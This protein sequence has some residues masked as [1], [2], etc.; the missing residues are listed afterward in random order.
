MG[1]TFPKNNATLPSGSHRILVPVTLVSYGLRKIVT[2][3]NLKHAATDPESEA[4]GRNYRLVIPWSA[5]SLTD[6]L[7]HETRR[8]ASCLA[9]EFQFDARDS[10]SPSN[11]PLLSSTM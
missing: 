8:I 4:A 2:S 7:G 1:Q 10:R 3:V 5:D 9:F 11:S 6:R